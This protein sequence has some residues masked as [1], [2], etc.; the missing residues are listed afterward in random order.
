MRPDSDEVALW[1]RDEGEGMDEQVRTHIF[2]RF[3]RGE[4]DASGRRVGLGLAIA[5]ALVDA[6]EGSIDVESSLG[7]GAC[8]TVRLPL[9]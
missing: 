9:V 1:V 4:G 7:E 5:K 2:E 8:F 3:F 6:H